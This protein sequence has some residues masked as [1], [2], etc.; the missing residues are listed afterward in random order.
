MQVVARIDRL[1]R[2][3]KGRRDLVH[4]LKGRGCSARDL[5]ADRHEYDGKAF[6]DILGVLAE[7]EKS[8]GQGRQLEGIAAKK[9]RGVYRGRRPYVHGNGGRRLH[10]EEGI[11][12]TAIKR[13]LDFAQSSVYRLTHSLIKA[14]T[15]QLNYLAVLVA[16]EIGFTNTRS[17]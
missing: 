3:L 5:A 14:T 13:C 8:L 2:L 10:H 1:A 4:E 11:G 7:F 12:A 9:P 17:S 6:L 15:L 16:R